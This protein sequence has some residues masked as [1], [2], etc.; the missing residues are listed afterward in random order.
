MVDTANNKLEEMLQ[1]RG[2]KPTAMRIL[3]LKQL[4]E[5][6]HAT[7]HKDLLAQFDRADSVT[8]F[9]TLKTFLEHKLI[10]S[11]DDGTGIVKYALCQSDCS[12]NPNDSHI[13]FHCT[14]CEQ[15]YCFVDSHI[16][17]LSIPK[18]YT[19]K[20]LNLVIKGICDRCN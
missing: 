6:Q 5:Q 19:A 8:L 15:T 14:E 18:N 20:S 7:S 12:C 10:H 9:R 13:H 11:I 16:P 17:S 3:I 1:S 4:L 2:I